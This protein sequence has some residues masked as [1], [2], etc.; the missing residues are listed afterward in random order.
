MRRA[1]IELRSAQVKID[2]EVELRIKQSVAPHKTIELEPIAGY[3]ELSIC[4]SGR[5]RIGRR[6]RSAPGG[7]YASWLLR[8]KFAPGPLPSA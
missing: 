7:L 6:W 4:M 8:P 3:I 2:I 1:V 5:E